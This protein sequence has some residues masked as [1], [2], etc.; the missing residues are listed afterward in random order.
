MVINFYR[1]DDHQE[2]FRF[3]TFTGNIDDIFFTVKCKNRYPRIKKKLNNGIELID[4]W[5]YITF[6]PADT[7]GLDCNIEMEYD[8]EIITGGK[9]YTVLKGVFTLEEDITTPDCEV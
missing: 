6:V 3:K 1:G 2:K 5:Y 4:D 7:E 8:I 9:K